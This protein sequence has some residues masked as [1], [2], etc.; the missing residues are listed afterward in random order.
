MIAFDPSKVKQVSNLLK[1]KIN[2]TPLIVLSDNSGCT[3][4]S[5][6]LMSR[7]WESPKDIPPVV[8]N[9]SCHPTGRYWE[10]L[11]NYAFK[12]AAMTFPNWNVPW[13]KQ[14]RIRKILF[15]ERLIELYLV[16][17][18]SYWVLYKVGGEH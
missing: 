6:P 9:S 8:L 15:I 4:C 16:G 10:Y 3:S 13:P 18:D 1:R 17:W 2:S 14:N 5:D 12:R 7:V 11:S